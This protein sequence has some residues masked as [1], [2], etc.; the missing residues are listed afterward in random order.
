MAVVDGRTMLEVLTPRACRQLLGTARIGRVAVVVDGHPEVFPIAYAM[1]GDTV[2]FRTDTGTKLHA[3]VHWPS[4][5]F[6]AD[7]VDEATGEAWSVMVVGP[8]S[9]VAGGPDLRRVRE[10]DLDAWAPGPGL[11]WLQITPRKVTGRRVRHD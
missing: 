6:E 9:E 1:D 8:V 10:L 7:D 2:V 5:A 3:A 4:V 11:H